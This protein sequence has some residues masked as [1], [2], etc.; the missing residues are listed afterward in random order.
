[1]K[2]FVE[3]LYFFRLPPF[4]QLRSGSQEQVL[5]PSSRYGACLHCYRVKV[6]AF[7]SLVDA[8]SIIVHTHPA[9]MIGAVARQFVHE[10]KFLGRA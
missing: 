10:N 1:M 4:S 6:S 8:R 9:N 7:S 2:N 5:L 3:G